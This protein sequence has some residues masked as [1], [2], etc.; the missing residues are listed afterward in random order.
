MTRKSLH[1]FNT[2]IIFEKSIFDLWLVESSGAEPPGTESWLY[3][4][5]RLSSCSRK[6]GVR[7]GVVWL[8]YFPPLVICLFMVSVFLFPSGNTLR[9]AAGQWSGDSGIDHAMAVY[10]NGEWG[11]SWLVKMNYACFHWWGWW[12]GPVPRLWAVSFG[13][14][15]WLLFLDGWWLV[16]GTVCKAGPWPG[17]LEVRHS[18]CS[19]VW[20]C[21]QHVVEPF[22]S[23]WNIMAPEECCALCH[24][25]QRWDS[26]MY[27]PHSDH[28]WSPWLKTKM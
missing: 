6:S 24:T 20:F 23:G 5:T 26:D 7:K 28:S 13:L 15:V 16:D 25:W 14:F 11:K 17:K 18:G 12:W 21:G 9:Q 1:M 8:L 27:H 19:E 4:P 10:R 2:G 22:S 3:S